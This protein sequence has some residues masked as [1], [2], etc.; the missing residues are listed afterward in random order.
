MHFVQ[1]INSLVC[2]DRTYRACRQSLPC[3]PLTSW[4]QDWEWRPP[5]KVHSALGLSSLDFSRFW[6]LSCVLLLLFLHSSLCT[7]QRV[8]DGLPG[9]PRGAP[10]AVRA[11]TSPEKTLTASS[12]GASEMSRRA[13]EEAHGSHMFPQLPV[14]SREQR[15]RARPTEKERAASEWPQHTEL[16]L[17]SAWRLASL[18]QMAPSRAA[19]PPPPGMLLSPEPDPKAPALPQAWL[20][21]ASLP[22]SA[23]LTG[24][25]L[26]PRNL[27]WFL[28]PRK[29]YREMP[30]S[31][32]PPPCQAAS[33]LPTGSGHYPHT[34]I[35][36]SCPCHAICTHPTEMILSPTIFER[37]PVLGWTVCA[38]SCPTLTT[39]WTVACQAPLSIGFPRQEYWSGLPFPPPGD[40]P[41]P[42]ME[43]AFPVTP[44]LVGRFSYLWVTWEALGWAVFPENLGP[45]ERGE[46]GWI[47]K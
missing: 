12:I 39:P 43:L 16:H 14:K 45:S 25:S 22:M 40:L 18:W 2:E 10:T 6:G 32:Y 42:G 5:S 30:A 41:N 27:P 8:G 4:D 23:L 17:P 7:G 47:W 34:P 20:H 9:T 29:K 13:F 35:P 31:F 28:L 24:S 21:A 33:A 11:D 44:A 1:N 19:D 26:Q 36:A 15:N 46:C 3:D 38:Q 37:W